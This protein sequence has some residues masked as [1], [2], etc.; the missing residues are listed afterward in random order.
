MTPNEACKITNNDEI[1]RINNIKI[2]EFEKINKKRKYLEKNDLCLMNPKV[3]KIGK[4]TLIPNII[5]KDKNNKKIPVKILERNGY[6]YYFIKAFLNYNDKNINI[7]S[8]SEYV[9]DCALL[10]KIKKNIWDA[11]LSKITKIN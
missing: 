3:L 7:K 11:I 5:K 1:K 6:G 2:K 9:V 10:K 8:G 4:N